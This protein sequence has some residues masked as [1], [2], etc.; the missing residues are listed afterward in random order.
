MLFARLCYVIGA[1]GAG[2]DAYG[3][4]QDGEVNTGITFLLI[5]VIALVLLYR[6]IAKWSDL[7]KKLPP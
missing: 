1:A 4:F 7:K 5:V 6:N 2:A 3:N